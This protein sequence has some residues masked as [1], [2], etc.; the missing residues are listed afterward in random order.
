MGPARASDVRGPSDPRHWF[1]TY[2]TQFERVIMPASAEQ[3]LMAGVTT[4]RDLAAP[5]Q[6]ILAVKER[7]TSAEIPGPTL[8]IAG[9]ALTKGANPN[10][11]QTWNGSGAAD[12]KAKTSQLIDA[13]VDWI[14]VINAESLAPHEM[15]AIVALIR[16]R[17]RNGPR[18]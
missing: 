15:K 2:T 9:P 7:I 1:D 16:D 14:K 3:M 11:V 12:A 8:Y 18:L 6:A 4:V 5:L 17:V 10:A 13:G